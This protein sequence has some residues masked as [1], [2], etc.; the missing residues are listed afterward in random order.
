MNHGGAYMY[1][2]GQFS[3]IARISM[4]ALRLYDEIGLL[5]PGRVDAANGYR[6]Y[7]RVQL[8]EAARILEWRK[9]GFS[10]QD[11]LELQP[12]A[13]TEEGR[14][15]LM[16]RLREKQHELEAE[17]E[18]KR[19]IIGELAARGADLAGP[20]Q[21]NV[22]EAAAYGI[23]LGLAGGLY[24]LSCRQTT[25]IQDAGQLLGKLYEALFARSLTA[26]GGHLLIYH[27]EGY[28]P[29]S[30]DLEAG[31]PIQLPASGFV[32][33]EGL[34]RFP[35]RL[36]ASTR[37]NGSFS[38]LGLAHAAVLDWI[39]DNGYEAD[40]PPFEQYAPLPLGRFH[41]SSAVT[42]VFYPVRILHGLRAHDQS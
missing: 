17:V 23:S 41:P 14:A 40:G 31:L 42:T 6:Y 20:A 3:H 15:E 35:E 22:P 8:E 16:G 33:P 32:P 28:E 38:K 1:T 30:T 7:S 5:K 4:K 13:E 21:E 19:L 36:C 29:D 39:R 26:S 12:L 10:L 9:Y 11:M 24:M 2:R 37:H 25:A 18:A 27:Q 34:V